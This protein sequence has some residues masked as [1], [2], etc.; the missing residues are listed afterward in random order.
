MQI[1]DAIKRMNDPREWLSGK[2]FS[3]QVEF[4]NENR[5]DETEFDIDCSKENWRDELVSLW[6]EFSKEN[7]LPADCVTDIWSTN[8]EPEVRCNS[9]C[10]L[11]DDGDGNW[12]C[13]DCGRDIHEIEDD[14]CSANENSFGWAEDI[15]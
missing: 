9:C 6:D 14:E 7:D 2:V 8:C 15:N 13:D 5:D 1:T 4:I 11:V 10:Y 12:I 3:I